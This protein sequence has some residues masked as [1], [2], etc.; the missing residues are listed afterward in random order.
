MFWVWVSL[1]VGSPARQR[2][3]ERE[4]GEDGLQEE[5]WHRHTDGAVP[6][7][8]AMNELESIS[9]STHLSITSHDIRHNTPSRIKTFFTTN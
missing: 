9:T 2:L 8:P 3:I 7:D 4:K 1:F 5:I 6:L